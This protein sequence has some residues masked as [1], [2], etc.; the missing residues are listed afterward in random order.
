M[1]SSEKLHYEVM[2][3]DG[4]I[5]IPLVIGELTQLTSSSHVIE[6]ELRKTRPRDISVRA[7]KA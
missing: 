3:L 1:T 5:D 6:D 4:A 2:S 7:D